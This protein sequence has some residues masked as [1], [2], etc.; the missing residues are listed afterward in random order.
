M[1]PDQA[2]FWQLN[3]NLLIFD[4]LIITNLRTLNLLYDFTNKYALGL[5][6]GVEEN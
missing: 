1:L 6:D 2:S 4:I 3:T 5:G